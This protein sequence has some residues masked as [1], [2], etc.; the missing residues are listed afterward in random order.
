MTVHMI[1]MM[2]MMMMMKMMMMMMVT[3]NHDLSMRAYM[4]RMN[5]NLV[6]EFQNERNELLHNFNK[7]ENKVEICALFCLELSA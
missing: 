4:Y 6:K 1:Q 2:M 3:I 7:K 5:E